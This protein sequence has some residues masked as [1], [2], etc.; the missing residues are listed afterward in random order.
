MTDSSTL[1]NII[2]LALAA[3]FIALRLRSVLG[4]RTGTEKP[5]PVWTQRLNGANRQDEAQG[6]VIDLDAHRTQPVNPATPALDTGPAGIRAIIAADPSFNPNAFLT[7][8]KAAFTM[9]VDAFGAGDADSLRPL[10]SDQVFANFTRAMRAPAS[11]FPE[12]H[13]LNIVSVDILDAALV[14]SEGE[15]TVR[16]VSD[17]SHPASAENSSHDVTRVVDLWTFRRRLRSSDPTWILVATRAAP[18]S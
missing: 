1:I 4:R 16:F 11:G 17:Q 10:V 2:L 14:G 9:I 13:V 7:G 18:P 15:V 12:S 3:A 8:A 6:T 5:P